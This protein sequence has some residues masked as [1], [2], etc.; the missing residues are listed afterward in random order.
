MLKNR[1]CCYLEVAKVN[2][3]KE[4]CN[5]IFDLLHGKNDFAERSKIL[6]RYRSENNFVE[7][8]K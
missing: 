7:L 5:V 8:S 1:T 6:A 2:I 3:I 4:E